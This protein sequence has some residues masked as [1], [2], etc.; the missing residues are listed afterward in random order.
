[1]AARKRR[2]SWPVMGAWGLLQRT[3]M[4]VSSTRP[5]V[6]L[7]GASGANKTKKRKPSEKTAIGLLYKKKKKEKQKRL[8]WHEMVHSTCCL[9]GRQD[10]TLL[11]LLGYLIDVHNVLPARQQVGEVHRGG[12]AWKVFEIRRKGYW[13]RIPSPS[14][15]FTAQ[16]KNI[17]KKW[18][19][20][21]G[22]GGRL[23][24]NV[25]MDT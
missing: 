25:L 7:G 21:E 13:S 22:Q 9:W 4:A 17:L 23:E 12:R 20:H 8:F 11:S 6:G 10:Q 1:M 24:G 14:N 5:T 19:I 15:D 16:E 3:T 18:H 2:L